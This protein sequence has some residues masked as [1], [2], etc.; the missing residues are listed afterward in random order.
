MRAAHITLFSFLI[1]GI[2]FLTLEPKKIN[3]L[4]NYL[5][6]TKLTKNISMITYR[7]VC[8]IQMKKWPVI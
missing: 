1:P 8:M 5:T 6:K 7:K 2:H 4:R 3:H